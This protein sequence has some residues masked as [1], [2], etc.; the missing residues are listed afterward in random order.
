M[1]TGEPPPRHGKNKHNTTQHTRARRPNSSRG[2]DRDRGM[3]ETIV[4]KGSKNKNNK[5]LANSKSTHHITYYTNHEKKKGEKTQNSNERS[6]QREPHR[7]TE[8]EREHHRGKPRKKN[9][10]K[11]KKKSSKP[12]KTKFHHGGGGAQGYTS[13]RM[14]AR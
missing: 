8:K 1:G 12:P 4:G 13:S 11:K 2:I 3:D 7:G 9:E 5:Q 14:R 10:I 6:N